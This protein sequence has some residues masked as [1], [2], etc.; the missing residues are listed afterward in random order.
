MCHMLFNKLKDI[1][2]G[3][4]KVIIVGKVFLFQIYNELLI[5]NNE[6]TF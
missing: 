5:L 4:K 2:E 6:I 1:Y 3:H